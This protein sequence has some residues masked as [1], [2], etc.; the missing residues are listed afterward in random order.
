MTFIRA[1]DEAVKVHSDDDDENDDHFPEAEAEEGGIEGEQQRRDR[2]SSSKHPDL[3]QTIYEKLQRYDHSASAALVLKQQLASGK[4]CRESECAK[5][6]KGG[7]PLK[8]INKGNPFGSLSPLCF[9]ESLLDAK[10][11][12]FGLSWDKKRRKMIGSC[13]ERRPARI[14]NLRWSCC[15]RAPRA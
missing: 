5:I 9:Q 7:V 6:G 10:A 3:S 1:H 12:E 15:R 8:A 14:R 11:T 13:T 2:F 4:K